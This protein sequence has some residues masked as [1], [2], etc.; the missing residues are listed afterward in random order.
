MIV[1]YAACRLRAFQA[2]AAACSHQTTTVAVGMPIQSPFIRCTRLAH[3]L[4]C[5]DEMG[6]QISAMFPSETACSGEVGQCL[7][8]DQ[9]HQ[10]TAFQP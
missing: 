6:A 2:T 9:I 7:T 4:G 10:K 1:P 3:I 8:N 5:Q